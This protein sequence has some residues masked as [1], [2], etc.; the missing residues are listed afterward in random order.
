M[1]KE[2]KEMLDNI[3]HLLNVIAI[4]LGFAL[5]LGVAA[6]FYFIFR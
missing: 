1:D 4:E 6:T 2:L 3:T 5:S